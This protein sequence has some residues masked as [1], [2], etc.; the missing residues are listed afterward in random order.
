M[1]IVLKEMQEISIQIQSANSYPLDYDFFIVL[2]HPTDLQQ[3]I[4]I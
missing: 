3:K 1:K 2:P 4:L